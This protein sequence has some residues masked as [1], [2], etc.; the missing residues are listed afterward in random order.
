MPLSRKRTHLLLALAGLLLLAGVLRAEAGTLRVQMQPDMAAAKTAITRLD[1]LVSQIELQ[2]ADGT[3]M[4]GA[5]WFGFLGTGSKVSHVD[6]TGV[7]EGRYRGLRFKVG[8]DA[9]TNARRPEEF[10]PEHPLHGAI[11]TLH[12]GWM[13]G[14]IFLAVEGRA[15]GKAFSFHLANNEN[16]TTVELPVNF[17]IRSDVTLTL[18]LDA[19]V[20]LS[21]I[22]FAKDPTSTHSR[23]GDPLLP[24]LKGGLQ[25]AFRVVSVR[26]DL[27]QSLP[28]IAAAAVPGSAKPFALQVPQRFPQLKLPVDNPLTKE[29]VALG[30]RLFADKRLSINNTQSCASCHDRGQAFADARRFS[31]GAEGQT[32]KRNSMALFNLAWHDGFFWDGRGKTLREQVLMPI[33]DAHEM[34]ESLPRVVTKLQADDS[35]EQAFAK[36]YGSAGIDSE[37]IAKAL[38]Q[39]LLTLISDDSKFDRAVRKETKLSDSETRGLQLF[40]TEFDPARGLRGADCF[41]CHG[42]MLFTNHA[43]HNNGLALLDSDL[44]RLA[45]TGLPADKGKFKTPS[46][47][48]IALTAPYMHDGRFATLEE[49]VE[50]Y[51]TGVVQSETLDPNL[52]K[53]PKAGLQLTAQEKAD[54]VAFLRTLTDESFTAASAHLTTNP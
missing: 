52:A 21:E 30:A 51:S 37:R 18:A 24:K 7:P 33:Q 2:R 50:H 42:G 20:L 19:Q 47:R 41:H 4:P 10:A 53:H 36:A 40:V 14:F 48:N 54:L 29:G 23:A 31:L 11:D 5:D 1:W 8:L 39:H 3:W 27:L 46:L 22:D 12:W 34:N 16:Q 32:G 43:F 17:E 13:G 35:Y 49:V 44:G 15:E 25:K 28:K 6:A 45:V 26:N 9:A 38:E